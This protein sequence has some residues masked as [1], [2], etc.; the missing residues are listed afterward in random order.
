MT[1]PVTKNPKNV[2]RGKKAYETHL[3]KIK[4]GI[5]SSK[6][7]GDLT[8]IATPASTTATTIAT[9]TSTTATPTATP[10]NTPLTT[11]ATTAT[12]SFTP[13]FTLLGTG[14]IVVIIATAGYFYIRKPAPPTKPAEPP[15]K[16]AAFFH[17]Q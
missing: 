1:T 12:P 17:M 11:A 7:S 3:K 16:N 9:P 14:A 15:K 6:N 13:S 2:E 8:T 10:A 4:E 5:L